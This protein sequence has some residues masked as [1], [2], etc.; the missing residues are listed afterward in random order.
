MHGTAL[1]SHGLQD[2]RVLDRASEHLGSVRQQRRDNMQRLRQSM[3]DWARKL[4]AQN[5]SEEALVVIRRDRLCIPVK[6]GRQVTDHLS[7]CRNIGFSGAAPTQ[8][9][10]ICSW[11]RSPHASCVCVS[12]LHVCPFW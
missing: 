1:M 5:I 7:E 11:D 8:L 10:A 2:G 4:A 12:Q 9:D 3:N 6:S